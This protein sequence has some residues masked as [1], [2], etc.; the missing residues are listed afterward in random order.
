MLFRSVFFEEVD[1][2]TMVTLD[3]HV[4]MQTSAAP[5]YLKGMTAGWTSSLEKLKAMLEMQEVANS[6]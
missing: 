1:G 4:M 5:Q 3:V 6:N 2:G